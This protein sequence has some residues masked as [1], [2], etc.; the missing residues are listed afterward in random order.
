MLCHHQ[1][2][3]LVSSLSRLKLLLLDFQLEQTLI[4]L[5]LNE[6]VSE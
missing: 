1:Q 2:Y 4:L 3:H 6:L 5:H